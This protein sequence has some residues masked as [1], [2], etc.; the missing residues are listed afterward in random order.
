LSVERPEP[1]RRAGGGGGIRD[2]CT[3]GAAPL[4]S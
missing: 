2:P 4:V 3:T 1:K